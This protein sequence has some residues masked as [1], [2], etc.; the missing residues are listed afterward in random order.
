[1]KS[2]ITRNLI[3]AGGAIIVGLMCVLIAP[4]LLPPGFGGGGVPPTP[5]RT[6]TPIKPKPTNTPAPVVRRS[7]TPTLPSPTPTPT[8]TPTPP[9]PIP[10]PFD[11]ILNFSNGSCDTGTPSYSYTFIIDGTSLTLN[12]T[13]AGITTTGSFDPATGAFSTSGDV[14]PGV[15]TYDG[16][17]SYDGA[18]ITVEGGYSW[19]PDGGQTCTFAIAG[20]ATP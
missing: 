11:I 12:Q 18:T 19:T 17:I 16:T 5:T 2:H 1:M 14:G 15:E 10:S 4:P 7:P 20:T 9:L 3:L 8:V 13:D 6:R